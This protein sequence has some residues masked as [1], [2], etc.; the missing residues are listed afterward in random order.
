MSIRFDKK[1]SFESAEAGR[2]VPMQAEQTYRGLDYLVALMKRIRPDNYQDISAAEKN[3]KAILFQL[4]DKS[5]LFS[6][7]K[8]LLSQF[9]KSDLVPALTAGGMLS[10]RGFVQELQG[11]IKHKFIPALR[12]PNDFL[13]VISRIFFKPKDYYWVERVDRQLWRA[14]FELLGIQIS[15]TDSGLI[16]QL[17][18][19]MQVLSYRI[20]NLGLE[21]EMTERYDRMEDAIHPFLEQ[22]R[23]V[24]MYLD[25]GA[26][27]SSETQ[28]ILFSNIMENLHNCL[29]SIQWVQAQRG[30]YGTSLAQTYVMVRLQQQI[31]RMKIIIDVLDRDQH[32]DTDRF[33][34]YFQTVV[35]NENTKNSLK[36]FLSANLGLLAYQIAEH[37]GRKGLGFI[38]ARTRDYWLLFRSAMGGGVIVSFVAIIKNLLGLVPFPLFWQGIAYSVNYAAGFVA[39]DQTGTTLATKQPAYTASAVASSLDVKKQGEPDLRNLAITVAQVSRS[40]IASFAGNLILVFPLTYAL[41]WLFDLTT[42]FKIAD[43]AAAMKLLKDQHPFQSLALLYACFT[44]FFLFLSGLIAGYVENHMVYS[45]VAE[46]LKTH[47]VFSN[48]MSPRRI[49]LLVNFVDRYAGSLAGSIALGFFL[50]M[51]GPLGK[52]FGLPFDIRH[53]TISA[54]NTAIGFYGLDHVVP[55]SFLI[56][57]VVGVFLIGFLNFLVSFSLAFYVAIKSRGIYL[58]DYPA[59]LGVLRRYFFRYPKDF[60]L[61]P[62]RHRKVEDLDFV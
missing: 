51:A 50:G 56:T 49:R 48:T 54:G 61:P 3:F 17:Q 62:R 58:R 11:K 47:P 14:F 28:R 46:R 20:A 18:Q 44:G 43:D 55:L 33:I 53:I 27:I 57:V 38:A 36:A 40:Q 12:K 24:N 32:F 8:A 39:M 2:V 10:S 30:A 19:S 15:V 45:Q 60:L 21:K 35:R 7:R 23:L 41:A 22:N 29:Q 1:T 59:F 16:R 52:I 6:L 5:A 34:E 13:Y 26:S 4:Q 31:E 9:A 25:Q 42:G 37:K